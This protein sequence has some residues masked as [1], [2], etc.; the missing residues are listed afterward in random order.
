[1][2]ECV[3]ICSVSDTLPALQRPAPVRS[4]RRG[5]SGIVCRPVRRVSAPCLAWSAL[6]LALPAL[7]PVMCSLS[8][9]AGAG[10]G[11]RWG[12]QGEPGVGWSTLRVEKNSKKAFS[13]FLLSIPTPPSQI[14]T[15]LIVQ[16]S[17]NS[18]KNKKT[19]Y[20]A[21]ECVILAKE[22]WNQKCKRSV[23]SCCLLD[24]F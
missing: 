14:K 23:E 19:P 3:Q 1:M 13:A 7:L 9:C 8:G 16:V 17:K 6:V 5:R 10:R 4:T 2:L 21:I 22:R 15:H 18:E 11:H 12:I 20:G 24:L